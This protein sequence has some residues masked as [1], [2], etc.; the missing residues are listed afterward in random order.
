MKLFEIVCDVSLLVVIV[1]TSNVFVF[2]CD[3]LRNLLRLVVF[4]GICLGRLG[5]FKTTSIVFAIVGS[6]PH[7]SSLGGDSC[8]RC[9]GLGRTGPVTLVY[10]SVYLLLEIP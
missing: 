4:V 8:L 10:V 1:C 7:W 2:V 3:C 6:W 9:V 5:F